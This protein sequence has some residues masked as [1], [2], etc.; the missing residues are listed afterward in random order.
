M[1]EELKEINETL[2]KIENKIEDKSPFSLKRLI[3]FTKME[4]DSRKKREEERNEEILKIQKIQTESI[5]RQEKFSSVVAFTGAV[6][7]IV[8]IYNFIISNLPF[9]NYPTSLLIIKIIFLFLLILSLTPLTKI[10]INFWK[11]EVFGR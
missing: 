2:R 3:D 5:K 10:I 11:K 4:E 9:E 7:A 1:S 8:A 6:I